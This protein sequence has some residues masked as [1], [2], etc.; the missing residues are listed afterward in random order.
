MITA[1]PPDRLNNIVERKPEQIGVNFLDIF[2]A[3]SYSELPEN[4]YLERAFIPSAEIKLQQNEPFEAGSY[5]VFTLPLPVVELTESAPT[6]RELALRVAIPSDSFQHL[7]GVPAAMWN[8]NTIPSVNAKLWGQEVIQ[9]ESSDRRDRALDIIFREVDTM[10]SNGEFERCNQLLRMLDVDNHSTN[11]LLGY[12][13]I[14]FAAADKLAARDEFLNR[15][16]QRLKNY[17]YRDRLLAG[18]RSGP[19]R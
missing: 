5:T 18:L 3:G 6:H 16:E 13:S 7:V 2:E 10:L 4:V 11:L 1:L 14:T 17:P 12:L 15:V 9:A 8:D 19:A